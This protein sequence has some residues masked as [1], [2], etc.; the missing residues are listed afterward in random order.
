MQ[1]MAKLLVLGFAMIANFA[2]AQDSSQMEDLAPA[3]DSAMAVESRA[4]EPETADAPTVADGSTAAPPFKQM[5]H[6]GLRPNTCVVETL[7]ADDSLISQI[8]AQDCSLVILPD[9]HAV[10]SP[11]PAAQ[12][13]AEQDTTRPVPVFRRLT[14]QP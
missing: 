14:P 8:V 9:Y 3:E 6:P 1:N 4:T 10:G 13:G 5:K 11:P 2:L 12:S 7:F